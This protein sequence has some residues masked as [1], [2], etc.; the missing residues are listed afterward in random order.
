[1][2]IK[3]VFYGCIRYE[4]FL[5]VF[6]KVFFELH[7]ATTNRN[8]APLY[9]IFAYLSFFRLDELQITDFRKLV[10]SQEP[11]KMHG[12]LQFVFNAELLKQHLREPW[13]ALYDF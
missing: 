11:T 3:Q 9:C 8:D 2:F 10:T 12:V 1:M 13:M 7:T 4:Q 5:K 6:T